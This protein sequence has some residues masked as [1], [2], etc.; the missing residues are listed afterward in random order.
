[1]KRWRGTRFIASREARAGE[2]YKKRIAEIGAADT[3]ISRCYSGKPMRVIRNAYV[4]DWEGRPEDIAPFPAQMQASLANGV[5]PLI[6]EHYDRVDPSR[7]CLPAGQGS[8]S[9]SDI[10]SCAEIVERVVRVEQ[11]WD[12]WVCGVMGHFAG[13]HS[14]R[15]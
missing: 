6:A 4:D 9:I 11:T 5:F 1:M 8:G 10:P 7:D 15:E 14:L 3:I 13:C 2:D 12:G